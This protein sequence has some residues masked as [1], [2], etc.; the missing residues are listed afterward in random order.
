MSL[1]WL[2][3]FFW[4]T[5]P[6]N[7]SRPI[8]N[9]LNFY[10]FSTIWM[11]FSMWTANAPALLLLLS[12]SCIAP[13]VILA[14][15]WSAL[16]LLLTCSWFTPAPDLFLV[17]SCSWSCPLQ[18][19]SLYHHQHFAT[20]FGTARAAFCDTITPGYCGCRRFWRRYRRPIFQNNVSRRYSLIFTVPLGK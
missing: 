9:L 18:F 11:K 8:V 20:F 3:L 6:T 1:K 10:V 15:S 7:Q 12:C 5:G 14:C 16:G 4:L 13:G 2:W 19:G 17:Y